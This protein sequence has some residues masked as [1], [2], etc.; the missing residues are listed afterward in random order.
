M[1]NINVRFANVTYVFNLLNELT[2]VNL[3]SLPTDASFD[4]IVN[5]LKQYGF[6]GASFDISYTALEYGNHVSVKVIDGARG[7][8]VNANIT[9]V[10]L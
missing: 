8:K 2:D 4:V 1:A 6:K 7:V 3:P 10:D 5:T 9:N